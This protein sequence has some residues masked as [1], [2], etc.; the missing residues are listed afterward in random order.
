[1]S[2]TI[3]RVAV[4]THSD[5]ALSS[6]YFSACFTGLKAVFN[7]TDLFVNPQDTFVDGWILLAPDAGQLLRVRKEGKPAVIVNGAG[8]GFPSIDLDNVGGACA[9]T[10]HLAEQG[11]RRIGFIAGKSETSNG[12][13]RYKG[14][15]RGLEQHGIPWDPALVIEGRFARDGGRNA[16][17]Q[18]LTLPSLPTAVFAANDSMALGAWDVLNEKNIRVPH[19][20]ALAGF[21]DIPE[22]EAKGLT[23]VRQPLMEMSKQ[24]KRWLLDWMR[25]GQSP[26]AGPRVVT[27]EALFRASSII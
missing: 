9:V 5:P 10:V 12:R 2:R 13:D 24:A 7:E 20:M 22:A 27:G 8:E 6:P 19:A 16:M 3:F 14:Y 26:T 21:D 1:M 25:F 23:S 17:T 18:F 15:R 11:H 4:T